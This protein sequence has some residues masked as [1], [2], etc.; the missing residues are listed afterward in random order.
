MASLAMPYNAP[1][2]WRAAR[3]DQM[4]LL[5]HQ[6]CTKDCHGTSRLFFEG[7]Q[8]KLLRIPID[9]TTKQ[10]DLQKKRIQAA[11]L[12]S[13]DNLNGLLFAYLKDDTPSEFD[14][15][16]RNYPFPSRM[17]AMIAA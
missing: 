9:F 11:M 1:L 15:C 16:P 4:Q 14:Q 8:Q 12:R 6:Q 10:Q 3:A 7:A 2:R 5:K 17:R 13:V